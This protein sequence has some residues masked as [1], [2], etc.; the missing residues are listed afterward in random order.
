MVIKRKIGDNLF[1]ILNIAF[2]TFLVLVTLYPFLYVVMASVSNSNSFAAHTGLLLKPAGF[3]LEAYKAVLKNSMIYIGYR[4]TIFYV[5]VGT[6]L[7]IIM[8]SMGAYVLT[9]KEFYLRKFLAKAIIITMFFDGGLIP[10]YLLIKSLHL[11][12]TPWVLI[13]SGLIS[14]WNLIVMRTNFDAIPESLIESATI[15]GANEFTILFR[16]ILPLS[17]PIIAV[18]ILYYGVAHWNEWFNAMIYLRTRDL[19]PLQLVLREILLVN[20][21]N[22]M[23]MDVGQNDR[24]SISE[25]IKYAT[26]MAA[27]LPILCVYPFMQKYFVKGVMIGAVKG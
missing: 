7:N 10:T 18:M 5:V 1:D 26:I 17:L 2:L 25:T 4:N 6:V 19:Y 23:M 20:D 9:R 21:T 8:T 16:I 12:N 13:V 15:D 3:S 27:T 14:T 11:V 22:S 24:Q